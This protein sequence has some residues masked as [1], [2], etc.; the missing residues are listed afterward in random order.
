MSLETEGGGRSL[1]V[2]AFDFA[3]TVR[4]RAGEARARA[5]KKSNFEKKSEIEESQLI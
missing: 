3:V 2:Y 4:L 1:R 5:Q